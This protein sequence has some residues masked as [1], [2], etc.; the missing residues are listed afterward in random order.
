[1]IEEAKAVN[2]KIVSL[3]RLLILLILRGYG[4]EEVTFR[5]LTVGLSMKEGI[6]QSHIALLI[7]MGYVKQR[8]VPF[9]EKKKLTVYAITPEG[10]AA[11]AKFENLFGDWAI[12]KRWENG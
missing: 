12:K 7:K 4:P 10:E 3:K 6:F 8:K 5:E 1:M 2:S 11:L 9:N